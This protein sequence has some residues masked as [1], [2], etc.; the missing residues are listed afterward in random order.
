M[1]RNH[2]KNGHKKT[3]GS[4][5]DQFCAAYELIFSRPIKCCSRIYNIEKM[6]S[7][8]K[9]NNVLWYVCILRRTLHHEI[10][11]FCRCA[12]LSSPFCRSAI[13]QV[14]KSIIPPFHH[15]AMPPFHKSIPK[16]GM[17]IMYCTTISH[18]NILVFIVRSKEVHH[19]KLPLVS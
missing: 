12:I 9:K 2:L 13:P 17:I 1:T 16:A 15:S 5:F 6:L 11:P 8:K 10:P 7:W 3:I 4:D 18:I 14:R 19:H